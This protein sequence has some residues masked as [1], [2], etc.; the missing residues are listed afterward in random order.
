MAQLVETLHHKTGGR[1]FDFRW[2][3]WNVSSE[4]ALLSAFSPLSL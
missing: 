2:G 4:I 1:G 3:H